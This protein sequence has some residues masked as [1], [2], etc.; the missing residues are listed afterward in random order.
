ME[1][2]P[3]GCIL[4]AA[5]GTGGHVIPALEVARALRGRGW[6]CVFVGTPRGLENRLVPAADFALERIRVGSLSRVSVRR[7]LATLLQAPRALAAA[8]GLVRRWGPVAALSLGGYASGPLA[9]ACAVLGVPLVALEPNA[10]PGL[11]NRL[12][13]PAVRKALLAHPQA[14]KRFRAASCAVTGL[15]VRREFFR[16]PRRLPGPRLAVLV[17][18][19]SRGAARLNQAALGAA[20]VWRREG[21]QPPRVAHQTGFEDLE[22]TAAAYRE[23]GSDTEA[24][25]FFD[26]LPERYARTDLAICRAG[27]SVAAELCAAR[28]P[29]VLVPFP[30]AADDHQTANARVLAEAG[31]ALLVR[32]SDW[33]GERMAQE[34]ARLAAH[35]VRLEA[36]AAAL[37]PLAPAGATERAAD[38]VEEAAAQGGS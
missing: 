37:A 26:D 38:A 36:M 17:L 30:Y 27:A 35:P 6:E 9:A 33:T 5:G 18:G 10:H 28:L 23:L 34:I 32:D 24:A 13:A 15:P 8:V 29:A 4:V 3:R 20:R 22:R 11:A 19:G 2:K 16:V 7:Q 21:V 1:P 25:A 31:G 12:A 14:A